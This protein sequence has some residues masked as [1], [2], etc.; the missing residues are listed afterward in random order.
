MTYPYDK[1]P[2]ARFMDDG[3]GGDARPGMSTAAVW[4]RRRACH[5]GQRHALE[6]I[7]PRSPS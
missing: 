3:P 2:F 5:R 1:P 4:F 6:C 7:F